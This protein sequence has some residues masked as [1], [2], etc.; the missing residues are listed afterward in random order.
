MAHPHPVLGRGLP[1]RLLPL[2]QLNPGSPCARQARVRPSGPGTSPHSQAQGFSSCHLIPAWGSLSPVDSFAPLGVSHPGH[3]GQSQTH[4]LPWVPRR[5]QGAATGHVPCVL[6][7]VPAPRWVDLGPNEN[8]GP[9]SRL[10]MASSAPTRRAL[11]STPA[12]AVRPAQQWPQQR[13][14][15]HR[16]GAG[17]GALPFSPSSQ[18]PPTTP[19][20]L[21]ML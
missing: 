14:L 6:W 9:W 7:V 17:L 10:Q 4:S 8:V 11:L 20:F 21:G 16:A 3:C 1:L 15:L 12:R 18:R 2:C 13:G 5:E 19:H